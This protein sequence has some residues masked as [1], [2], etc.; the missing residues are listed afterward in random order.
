MHK[1]HLF[2]VLSLLVF[3]L[4]LFSNHFFKQKDALFDV[5]IPEGNYTL[6][7]DLS[8]HQGKI[9]WELLLQKLE[10]NKSPAFF[11][12]KVT[13]GYNHV[14]REWVRNRKKCLEHGLKHGAYHF[15]IPSKSGHKQAQH[16]L[17]NY[18]YTE[19]D[20][21]PVLD[22]EIDG[23][24]LNTSIQEARN[25]LQEV[26]RRIGIRPIIYTSLDRY[27]LQLKMAFPNYKFWVA[28]YS[29]KIDLLNN[30]QII[31]WQFTENGRLPGHRV[32]V[33]LNVSLMPI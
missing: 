23:N 20:L 24:S 32:N 1:F 2:S 27:N 22:Y 15:F 17:S 5:V 7:V 16:F 14:D 31:H 18:K 12:L 11:Y 28:A 26:E 10:S 30:P 9:D 25:W 6:G 29:R 19:G 3:G 33:D 13:E 4:L 21:P 8:H